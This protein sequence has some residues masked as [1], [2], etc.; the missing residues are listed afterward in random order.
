MKSKFHLGDLHPFL[1]VALATAQMIT[2]TE[3]ALKLTQYKP[4]HEG[5]H[6]RLDIFWYVFAIFVWWIKRKK[7]YQVFYSETVS[8]C[9]GQF[10]HLKA[11]IYNTIKNNN[12]ICMTHRVSIF[13]EIETLFTHQMYK[14]HDFL[15]K[16]LRKTHACWVPMVLIFLFTYHQD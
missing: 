7:K 13:K 16:C 10:I 9:P 12:N 5:I 14:N 6:P 2:L 15:H 4:V 3:Q 8:K 11:V 1:A